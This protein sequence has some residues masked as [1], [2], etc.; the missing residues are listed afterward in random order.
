[1]PKTPK[2][3]IKKVLGRNNRSFRITDGAVT[4]VY[5]DYVLFIKR[6]TKRAEELAAASKEPVV[7]SDHF[8]EAAELV[9]KEFNA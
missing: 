7:S 4:A 1:M 8:R 9:L 5:L 2:Q 3:Q 6:L